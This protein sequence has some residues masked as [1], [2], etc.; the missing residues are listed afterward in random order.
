[1]KKTILSS[2]IIWYTIIIIGG[3]T[4]GLFQDMYRLGFILFDLMG[5]SILFSIPWFIFFTIS[6]LLI[7]KLTTNNILI[8]SLLM[9]MGNILYYLTFIF[10]NYFFKG[11]FGLA[12]WNNQVGNSVLVIYWLVTC[13]SIL[14]WRIYL[15]LASR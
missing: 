14:F 13:I 6:T 4:F 1:M 15:V 2:V 9:L 5:Y 11:E 8:N 3:L 10:L 12:F 7:N